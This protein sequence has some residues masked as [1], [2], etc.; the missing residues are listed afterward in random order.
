PVPP[1]TVFSAMTVWP[2]LS[3]LPEL[4]YTPPPPLAALPELPVMVLSMIE[5]VALLPGELVKSRPP[6]PV[7]AVL[8]WMVELTIDSDPPLPP[9]YEMPPPDEARLPLMVTLSRASP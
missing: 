5:P 2:M 3:R 7:A 1:L 8:P 9:L 6:P 4:T